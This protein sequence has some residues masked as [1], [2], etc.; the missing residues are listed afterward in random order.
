MTRIHLYED[1]G[2]GLHLWKEGEDRFIS[3]LERAEAEDKPRY[4]YRFKVY[5]ANIQQF[6][7][8]DWEDPTQSW[9]EPWTGPPGYLVATWEGGKVMVVSRP[10]LAAAALLGIKPEDFEG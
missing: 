7:Y 6:G 3:H 4:L 9:L 1:T 8:R 2:G 10:G 5:A